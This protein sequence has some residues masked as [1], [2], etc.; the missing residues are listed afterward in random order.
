M[1]VCKFWG[2]LDLCFSAFPNKL[3]SESKIMKAALKVM[4]PVLLCW[5]TM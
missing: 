1:I 3:I 4:L 2:H 5:L